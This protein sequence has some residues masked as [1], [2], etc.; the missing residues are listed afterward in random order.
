MQGNPSGVNL[1][2]R[3]VLIGLFKAIGA[4]AEKL[5]GERLT[6]TVENE[7]GECVAISSQ[8]GEWERIDQAA[9]SSHCGHRETP[10]AMQERATA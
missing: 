7:A 1:T 2:D 9:E 5:T 8:S 10:L 4:L 6:I 3:E